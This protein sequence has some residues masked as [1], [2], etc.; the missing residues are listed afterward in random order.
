MG[1][2]PIVTGDLV[3]LNCLGH[4]NDPRILA[5]NKFNGSIVWSYI[6][7]FKQN[8]EGDSYATPIVYKDQAIIYASEDVSG[9]DLRTGE[10]IWNYPIRIADAVATPVLGDGIV[11]TTTHSTFSS[12]EMRDQFPLFSEI[13]RKY[14]ANGDRKLDKPEIMDY[15][16]L[17]YPEEPDVSQKMSVEDPC[18]KRSQR[19]NH[20]YTCGCR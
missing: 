11:Y 9:Y 5:I 2:S 1:T 19:I 18:T 8:Y 7:P 4:Q 15:T 12:P 13:L 16:F 10:R 14:D 6:M 20:G 3:I 17:I